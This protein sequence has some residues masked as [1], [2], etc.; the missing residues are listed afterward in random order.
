MGPSGPRDSWILFSDSTDSRIMDSPII[1]DWTAALVPSLFIH[2]TSA[3][4]PLLRTKV[5]PS[6]QLLVFQIGLSF[7]IFLL[8]QVTTLSG[9]PPIAQPFRWLPRNRARLLYWA[10]AFSV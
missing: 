2:S 6:F 3:L 5:V 7:W 9:L 8:L 4:R 1:R 10:Q